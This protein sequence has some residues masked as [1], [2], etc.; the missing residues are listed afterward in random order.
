MPR[1]KA[2]KWDP[3]NAYLSAFHISTCAV[4][5][6]VLALVA[7]FVL[8]DL[9]APMLPDVDTQK[10]KVKAAPFS[11]VVT[12]SVHNP[13]SYEARISDLDLL[14]TEQNTGVHGFGSIAGGGTVLIPAKTTENVDVSFMLADYT[15]DTL[16]LV[17]I[18]S[19]EGFDFVAIGNVHVSL[20]Y[21]SATVAIG[22]LKYH[23]VCKDILDDIIG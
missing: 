23:Y 13:N 20:W 14:V 7:V 8:V 2:D 15:K 11:V 9:G 21:A 22:A 10:T 6:L 19:N 16:E 3:A 1:L 5:T 17:E 12:V 4:L 18:C